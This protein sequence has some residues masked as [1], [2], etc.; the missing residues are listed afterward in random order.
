VLIEPDE[1]PSVNLGINY[2]DSQTHREIT[3][4]T[5]TGS[6]RLDLFRGT[7][8][9]PE[10]IETFTIG[11]DDTYLA[12]HAAMTAGDD[13]VI[14]DISEGLQVMRLIDAAEAAAASGQW[15]AA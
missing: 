1:V 5:E 10:G 4:L 3:A 11:R 14:C 9:T 6:V 13:T 8:E 15:M 7:L 2:L 12:Q